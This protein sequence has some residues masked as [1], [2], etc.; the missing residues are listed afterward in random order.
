MELS[1]ICICKYVS[2]DE[3]KE[4]IFLRLL[5][6]KKTVIKYD[7]YNNECVPFLVCLSCT[8]N[9]VINHYVS[10]GV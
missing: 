8:F 4:N 10:A 9:V 6:G 2:G 3:N 5:F 7:K 1:P